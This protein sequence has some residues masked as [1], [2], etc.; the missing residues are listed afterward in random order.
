MR[1]GG[2]KRGSNYARKRRRQ[3]LLRTFDPDLGPDAARCHLKL[4]DRCKG[5]VD[6][7]TLTVDRI[8][9]GGKYTRDNIQPA[10]IPCQTRQG[11]LITREARQQWRLWMDE[12]LALGI[13]WDG[14]ISLSD[15]SAEPM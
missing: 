9:P 7:S 14:A 1:A 5:A 13:E 10:C 6:Q 12:A 2:D 4:S 11:A 8:Q 15:I 3:W